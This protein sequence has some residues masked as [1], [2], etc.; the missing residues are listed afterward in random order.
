MQGCERRPCSTFFGALPGFIGKWFIL[1]KSIRGVEIR[2][3]GQLLLSPP[4]G[5]SVALGSQKR[6]QWF[7]CWL[8]LGDMAQKALLKG[9]QSVGHGALCLHFFQ[10][11]APDPE[12]SIIGSAQDVLVPLEDEM[13]VLGQLGL[14]AAQKAG[15]HSFS[16]G[17]GQREGRIGP[18]RR[19]RWW[20]P[21]PLNPELFRGNRPTWASSVLC[22]FKCGHRAKETHRHSLRI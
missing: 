15:C 3:Y 14:S 7:P 18:G 21:L 2:A 4:L 5:R 1:W 16:Q 10:A 6:L 13:L 8:S 12:G 22:P 20:P 11:S 19:W 17:M 9:E